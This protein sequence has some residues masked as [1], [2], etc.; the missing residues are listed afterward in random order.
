[1]SCTSSLAALKP[2]KRERTAS[3]STAFCGHPTTVSTVR[4]VGGMEMPKSFST[5]FPL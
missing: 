3:A 5:F 4:S 1:M 2:S